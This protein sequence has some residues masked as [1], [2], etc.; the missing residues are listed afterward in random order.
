MLWLPSIIHP[1]YGPSITIIIYIYL[2]EYVCNIVNMAGGL[3]SHQVHHLPLLLPLS[4]PRPLQKILRLRVAEIPNYEVMVIMLMRPFHNGF[5][6]ICI[7][8]C[9]WWER[10]A[11]TPSLSPPPCQVRKY[12][13]ILGC[14]GMRW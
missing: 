10:A 1:F 11:S 2:V 5:I 9:M 4:P 14:D 13:H 7:Y 6:Y 3:V 8:V 12:T